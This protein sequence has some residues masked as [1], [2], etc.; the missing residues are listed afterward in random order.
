MLIEFKELWMFI[1]PDYMLSCCTLGLIPLK[2]YQDLTDP[3]DI[4]ADLSKVGGVY[5]FV[6]TN[7]DCVGITPLIAHGPSVLSAI[8]SK[9][10]KQYIGSSKDMHERFTDH[11]IP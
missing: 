5:G 2:L 3:K 7:S 9:D 1:S 6:N 8:G 4:R 11:I 10:G